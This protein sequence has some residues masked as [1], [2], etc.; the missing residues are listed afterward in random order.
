MTSEGGCK[1]STIGFETLTETEDWPTLPAASYALTAKVW[2][3]LP[4]LA[5]FQE[6]E[7]AAE[8]LDVTWLLSTHNSVRTTPRLSVAKP[9]TGSVPLT[10]DEPVGFAIET[11]GVTVV[12]L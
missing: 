10:V 3:P 11:L 12:P 1:S 8:L 5:E 6:K 9:C 7:N 2:E 4:T